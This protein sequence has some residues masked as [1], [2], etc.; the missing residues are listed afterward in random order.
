MCQTDDDVFCAQ[1]WLDRLES[2]GV[3]NLSADDIRAMS[4]RRRPDSD[5]ESAPP[6]KRSR[7]SDPELEAMRAVPPE[8]AGRPAARIDVAG[9]RRQATCLVPGIRVAAASAELLPPKEKA[10]EL[11]PDSQTDGKHDAEDGP[12]NGPAVD[13]DD[14]SD[15][16][17]DTS[18]ALPPVRHLLYAQVEKRKRPKDAWKMVFSQGILVANGV[19]FAFARANAHFK[20]V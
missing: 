2:E 19:D 3:V 7:S 10:A 18:S 17:P 12:Q 20:M 16:D 14:D 8:S 6:T 4:R 11:P 15:G 13:A 1:F 5:D 9:Q